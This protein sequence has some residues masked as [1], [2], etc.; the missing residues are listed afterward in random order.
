MQ[1]KLFL[2]LICMKGAKK[3]KRVE[4]NQPHFVLFVIA[5]YLFSENILK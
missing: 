4:N 5:F 1:K 3:K 2:P